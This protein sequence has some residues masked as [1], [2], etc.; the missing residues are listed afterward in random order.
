M[1]ST[2][3]Q[4]FAKALVAVLLVSGGV[5]CTQNSLAQSTIVGGSEAEEGQFPWMSCL[6]LF[7]EE[8]VC[9]GALVHPE[10]VLTAAHC[11]FTEDL[12]L[13]SF[14]I[15]SIDAYGELNPNGGAER[16]IS[17]VHIH[18]EYNFDDLVGQHVDLAL[19][20]LSEPVTDIEPIALPIGMDPEELYQ[21]NTSVNLA[22]WGL[23]VE[24]GIN[25]NPDTLQWVTSNVYDFDGCETA[26]GNSITDDFFCIG[27]TEGQTP[28]GAATGDSGGPAWIYDSEDNATLTGIVH[29]ALW[30]FTGLD[31]PGVFVKVANQLEWIDSVISGAPTATLDR[32]AEIDFRIERRPGKLELIVDGYTGELTISLYSVQGVKL[33]ESIQRA[34]S[35]MPIEIGTEQAAS[36]YYILQLTTPSG[37]GAAQ[38]V[39]IY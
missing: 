37:L 28:S 29:G 24:D 16:N 23:V 8:A 2:R 11:V 25:S 26:I 36:G 13:L 3:Y 4:A 7:G 6:Y 9:G 39:G 30:D 5:L 32:D 20:R 14:R 15:N 34:S 31:Q 1:K 22:G 33:L 18:P 38:K 35:G 10:W 27:Y 12:D 19:F 17:E 21:T